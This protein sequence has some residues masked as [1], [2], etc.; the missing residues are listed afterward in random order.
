MHAVKVEYCVRD[1][2]I[3]ENTA[4]IRR[5]MAALRDAPIDGLKYAAF[6]RGDG[7]FIHLNIA[8]DDEALAKLTGMDEFKAFQAALGASQPVAPPTPEGLQLVAAGFDI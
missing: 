1:D 7:S 8:R 2:F 5:V 6:T 3:D 4:N